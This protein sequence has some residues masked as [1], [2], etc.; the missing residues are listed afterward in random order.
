MLRKIVLFAC[1]I[2]VCSALSLAGCSTSNSGGSTPQSGQAAKEVGT[3]GG[4]VTTSDG[5]GVTVP[6]GALSSNINITVQSDPGAPAIPRA[7][8]AVG[9]AYLFGPEGEEFS[10]PVTVT[11]AIDPTRLPTGTTAHDVILLTS[12]ATGIPNYVSLVTTVVDATHVSAQTT[13][14]SVL[15][16]AV[17]DAG[18]CNTVVLKQAKAAFSC[19]SL[20]TPTGGTIAD[21]TY[22]QTS[23][24]QDSFPCVE[25]GPRML[26]LVVSGSSWQGALGGPDGG[27]GSA[28]VTAT[29]NGNNLVWD[30]SCWTPPEIG[31]DGGVETFEYSATPTTLQLI[32]PSGPTTSVLTFT[33]QADGGGSGNTSAFVGTWVCTFTVTDAEPD[34][35]SSTGSE[36]LT[37]TAGADGEIDESSFL[38][39]GGFIC[40]VTA[41]T[42]SNTATLTPN[43][44][45]VVNGQIF[46][47]K[48]ETATVSG[49]TLTWSETIQADAFVPQNVSGICTRQ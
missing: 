6:S 1:L 39:D 28:N 41:S 47:I 24:I 26:T 3:G 31:P 25:D 36:T 48:S 18:M 21:G 37:I 4:S 5:S 44:S 7:W 49:N 22:V 45:C 33:K 23:V 9:T 8:V 11:L 19:G 38:P 27:V 2:A 29:T 13:H 30:W 32:T 40:A 46:E 12:P 35:G 20:P 16:P 43:Q 42:S 17:G 34:G 10:R 14:F 15:V